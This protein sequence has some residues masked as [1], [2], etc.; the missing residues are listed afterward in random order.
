MPPIRK[1]PPRWGRLAVR[2]TVAMAVLGAIAYLAA[3]YALNRYLHGEAFRQLLNAKTSAL[4]KAEGEYLPIQSNGFSFY[5]DGYAARGAAGAALKS[6]KSLKADQIRA[7]FEPAALFQGAWKVS[8]LEAQRL[9]VEVDAPSSSEAAALPAAPSISPAPRRSSWIPDRFEL[10]RAKIEEAELSWMP[11][12]H[13]RAGHLSRMR[14]IL[15]PNGRD[16]V[17]TGYGGRLE[18]TGWPALAVDHLKV[19]CRYPELFLT[20]SLFQIR[21][22]ETLNVSGQANLGPSR[23][24]DLMVKFNGVAI[25]P[26]LPDDWRAGVKGNA[27][28]EARV[29][30][31]L[32]AVQAAGTLNLTGA[33]LEAL[34]IL[35]KIAAF[36][37]TRQFRQFTLQKAEADFIWKPNLLTIS[38]LEAE[39]EG[40]IRLS[41]SLT[42]RDGTAQGDFQL[43]VAPATLRWLPGSRGRVFNQEHDGY[44]WTTLKVTGPLDHLQED[45]SA[46]LTAAA[47]EE[48]IQNVKGTLESGVRNLFD[49]LKPLAP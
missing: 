35:E 30:G 34:P 43:G 25:S 49:L 20:D 4:L 47:G 18:Q 29:T 16:L 36:T 22:G 13:P 2:C 14:L 12:E 45:L 1:T 17:A 11:P 31:S 6:L 19:R 46:R 44:A 8:S 32:D 27:S 42:V 15:E 24:L 37:R 7:E 21:D 41:G 39:S 48:I 40:L 9:R 26:Y 33:Q 38:R 23:T 28:G 5:S 3:S 10:Q